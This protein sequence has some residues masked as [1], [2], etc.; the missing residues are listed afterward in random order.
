MVFGFGLRASVINAWPINKVTYARM[1]CVTQS[2]ATEYRDAK[3]NVDRM[4]NGSGV[5]F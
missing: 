2:A 1:K 3:L 5:T 4:I